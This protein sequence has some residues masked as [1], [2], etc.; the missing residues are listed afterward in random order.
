VAAASNTSNKRRP[1][2]QKNR[3]FKDNVL[4]LLT[5]GSMDRK[6]TIER[7]ETTDGE[8]VTSAPHPA[9]KL[10]LYSDQQLKPMDILR[11]KL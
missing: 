1:R 10:W 11:K 4:E 2:L 3:F 6:F 8:S 5:P 7:M 9:Q